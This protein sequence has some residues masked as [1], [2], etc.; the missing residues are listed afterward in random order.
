MKRASRQPPRRQDLHLL[1]RGYAHPPAASGSAPTR[2]PSTAQ[3]GTGSP[4]GRRTPRRVSVD[5]RLQRLGRAAPP[6]AP[7]RAAPASGRASSPA[8]A[9]ARSTSTTSRR[10]HGGYRVD[11]ADPFAFRAEAPPRTA[12]VVWDLDYDWGDDDWMAG[13]RRAQRPRRADVGLRGAPRLLAARAEDGDRSLSYRELAPRSPS[14]CETLGFTHVELLPVMEHPFYGSWGY[15]TT[16]YFAP[17]AATARRRTS[18]TSIDHLHQQRDRRDPRLGAVAL[19]RPTSTGSAYF[20]GTHLYEHADPRQGFHP[21]WKSCDLQLRPPR[22]AQLP[23]LERALSGSSATT[24]TACGSTRSPR[25]STSTTRARRAS[26]S[27]TSYGGRENLEAIDFLR[28]LNETVYAD[29]PDVQTIAEESTAWPMVSRPTVR[30]RAR[31]RP[32]VGHGL[33][34][35]H[36]ATTSRATRSTAATTTTSCTFRTVYA[37]TENFMLP[38]SHDEVVHGKGSL[39]G[40]MP[41]DDW[42]QFANLRAAL[43]ATCTA[44][45][46][47][48]SCSWAASSASG[49]SGT[50]TRSLDWHLTASEPR[51]RA[52]SRLVDR[53][54]PPLPPR[55]RR[56]TSWTS[57]PEGFEWV[58]RERRR[59][60]R[61]ELPALRA[62]TPDDT[63]LC[64]VQLHAR[65]RAQLPRRRARTPAAGRDPEQRLEPTTAAAARATSAAST[66]RRCPP[67]AGSSRST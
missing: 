46:A 38:L 22:G 13:A 35:R 12:S 50:T 9:T 51:T 39:L 56:C 54:Q 6:A 64:V 59:G 10:A 63:V 3:A 41:G 57:W 43:R 17:T 36:P 28:R 5:R 15:Q 58:D 19:P 27:R 23:A 20:D 24:P 4:C 49:R 33:D 37:F 53:P 1:Q 18:C 44:S 48:S 62:G 47:R 66:P 26:G 45:P 30:G 16:G 8:S 7:A 2:R 11:K 31:L 32:Q 55:S 67:T 25:C 65:W 40:K 52:S 21:D 61:A 34:A 29:Y 60:Q 14:T 42:Q